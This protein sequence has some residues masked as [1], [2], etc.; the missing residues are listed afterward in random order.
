MVSLRRLDNIVKLVSR[1]LGDERD[2]TLRNIGKPAFDKR[3]VEEFVYSLDFL[4]EYEESL[5]RVRF[6][7]TQSA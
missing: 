6:V 5:V 7:S 3:S 2:D 1:P 4:V